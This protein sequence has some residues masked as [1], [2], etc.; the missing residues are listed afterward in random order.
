MLCDQALF[1][2]S[3][4]ADSGGVHQAP[5]QPSADCAAPSSPWARDAAPPASVHE[6]EG[7]KGPADRFTSSSASPA[8]V[9][10]AA[11]LEARDSHSANASQLQPGV[12]A[13]AGPAAEEEGA[14]EGPVDSF[15]SVFDFL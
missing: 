1:T 13:S 11:T 10:G 2:V 12:A 7:G 6:A 8:K 14:A 9:T 5:D 4:A 15:C 3:N